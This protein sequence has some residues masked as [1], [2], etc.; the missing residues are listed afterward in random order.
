MKRKKPFLL[1][2]LPRGR[3]KREVEAVG[4]EE[5]R[6]REHLERNLRSVNRRYNL[7]RD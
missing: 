3:E 5:G 7:D 6:S 4:R 2:S 1:V